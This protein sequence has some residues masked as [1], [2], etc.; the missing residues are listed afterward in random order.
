MSQPT[1]TFDPR[2]SSR[3]PSLPDLPPVEAPS[4]GFIVQLFVIPAV[5]VLVVVVVWLLF[6]KLAGGERDAMSYVETI[7]FKVTWTLSTE[8]ELGDS[9]TAQTW[10][11]TIAFDSDE[12]KVT[13]GKWQACP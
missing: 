10:D 1:E 12:S 3:A 8:I 13:L 2:D 4:A 5:I 7:K 6:G 9:S 11:A